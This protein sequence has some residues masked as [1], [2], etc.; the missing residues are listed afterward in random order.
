MESSITMQGQIRNF[1]F[2]NAPFVDRRDF[3]K[4]ASM[5]TAAG[6]LGSG[7]DAGAQPKTRYT[8]IH[9]PAGAHPALRSAAEILVRNLGLKENAI[10][11]YKGATPHQR[12]EI[13][14]ALKETRG[15]PAALS[16]P[17]ERDGYAVMAADGGL[18]VCGARP[19]SLLYAA[20]EPD[21]WTGHT[22]GV[23]ARNPD[24]ALRLSGWHP[25]LSATPL[26]LM[27]ELYSQSLRFMQE[28]VGP[29]YLP[30][31][32]IRASVSI[33]VPTEMQHPSR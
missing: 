1:P 4:A 25:R 5:T 21:E 24:F 12:G 27:H 22:S 10:A 28:S 6:A 18:M 2:R 3:L 32:Y 20:G 11:T 15:I 29:D 8:R 26:P 14:F 7:L 9:I 19:R 31:E 16:G 30:Q 23:W 13:V 17:I 33:D